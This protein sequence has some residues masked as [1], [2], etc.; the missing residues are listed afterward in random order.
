MPR[1][2]YQIAAQDVPAVHRW[3]HAKFRDTTW[4]QHD[5]AHTAWDAFPREQPTTTQLQ[6]WCDQHLDVAQWTQ[7]QA[8]IRAARRDARQTRTVRLS[9]S[10]HTLLHDLALREQ[11]TLSETIERYLADV[12]TTP[13]RQDTSPTI[14]KTVAKATGAHPHALEKAP[15]VV[16]PQKRGS[17]FITTQKGGVTS[18]SNAAGR[19]SRLTVRPYLRWFSRN[20]AKPCI[21]GERKA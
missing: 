9:T 11:L 16:V 14:E 20:G 4:P 2:R 3:V 6:Q 1:P 18:R 19:T 12:I 10:A 8:V 17:A 21:Q 7:L 13:T 5:A 15:T